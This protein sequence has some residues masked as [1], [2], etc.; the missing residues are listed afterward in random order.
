MKTINTLDELASQLALTFTANREIIEESL[1]SIGYQLS[2]DFSDLASA[3]QTL[4]LY[5]ELATRSRDPATFLKILDTEYERLTRNIPEDVIRGAARYTAWSYEGPRGENPLWMPTNAEL[6]SYTDLWSPINVPNTEII[7]SYATWIDNVLE[8]V[9]YTPSLNT[10][11]Q[12][13][14]VQKKLAE[15]AVDPSN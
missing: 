15:I 13:E 10:G 8:G 12:P 1:G 3:A 7:R 6:V 5:C 2:E 9:T 11:K 14:G 4:R